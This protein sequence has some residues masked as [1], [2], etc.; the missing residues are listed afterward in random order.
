MF[1]CMVT[2]AIQLCFPDQVTEEHL[3]IL[4]HFDVGV[5]RGECEVSDIH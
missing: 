5:V 4:V 1:C 3:V 2:Y